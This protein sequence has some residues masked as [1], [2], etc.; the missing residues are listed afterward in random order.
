MNRFTTRHAAR[1]AAPPILVA[2]MALSSPFAAV[3]Q[4]PELLQPYQLYEAARVDGDFA[5]AERYAQQMLTAAESQYGDESLELV[6]P[7]KRVAASQASAGNG[8]LAVASYERVLSIQQAQLGEGHPDTIP[9]L[10]ALYR[11]H[12]EQQEFAAAEQRLQAI[13]ELEQS[14]Y[15]ERHDNVIATL[16]R[17]LELYTQ[18][19][20]TDEARDVDQRIEAARFSE[21]TLSFDTPSGGDPRYDIEDGYATV[22]VFYGT[23]RAR[24]GDAKPA[25]FYGAGRGELEMGHLDVTIPAIH[26][27]GELE[28]ESRWSIYTYVLGEE[29]RKQRYV[30]LQ[31]VDPL[32]EDQFYARL[33]EHVED[34]PTNDVF[35]FVHGYNSTF[36]DAA[37]R[38]AQLAYDLDFDGTPMMYSWPSQ[39]S[40]AAYTVDE[41]VVR[42]S[43]RK[44]S[45]FIED[46]VAQSGAERVH[47]IAHSMGNRALIEALTAYS[48]RRGPGA[49]AN[50]FD[51]IVFT[52]PDV[53]RDYFT[54]VI[55]D[56]KHVAQRITLYA[57]QN[58]VALRTSRIVHGAPRAGQAGKTIISLPGLDTIDMSGVDA[59]LLGH[60]YFAANQGA[61]HDL[62]RL[63]WR[64]E[65]P[66]QRCGMNRAGSSDGVWSF[67]AEECKGVDLLRASVL[68]KRF[69]GSARDRVRARIAAITDREPETARREWQQIL[70]RLDALLSED[71]P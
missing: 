54:T 4:S 3:A 71:N 38:V 28:S 61:I 30:L 57:S 25:T 60:T 24:T 11:L 49:T 47:L 66:A 1:A 21:R 37:R 44:M 8:G 12:L 48:A 36:E 7:I 13:L 53:D 15:G 50:A 10:E 27:Y 29:A 68:I 19:G 69:G 58:D 42:L 46:I 2:V 18:Q 14:I 5:A 26:K 6:E 16:T 20:R 39:G 67:S 64:N 22:R 43:G 70:T 62:F 41:A 45:R 59:D 52:A 35:F 33:R 17:L 40:T 55:D 65:P 31:S 23:D 63:F 34:S 32:P 56:I 51:Q 9:T